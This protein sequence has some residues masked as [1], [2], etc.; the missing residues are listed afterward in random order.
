MNNSKRCVPKDRKA[1]GTNNCYEVDKMQPNN[2]PMSTYMQA[3]KILNQTVKTETY[4]KLSR[5]KYIKNKVPKL[6]KIKK[7]TSTTPD[8]W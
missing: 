7:L 4:D 6:Q 2:C 3:C 1:G 5:N 8:A